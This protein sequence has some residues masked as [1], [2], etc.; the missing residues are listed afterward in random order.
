MQVSRH[1]AAFCRPDDLLAVTSSGR[2][3]SPS[4]ASHQSRHST[5][6]N[7]SLDGRG[8]DRPTS[9]PIGRRADP[10]VDIHRGCDGGKVTTRVLMALCG[11]DVFEEPP[12]VAL[13]NVLVV[14]AVPDADWDMDA[15][16]GE[17]PW[18]GKSDLVVVPA[19]ETVSERSDQ[20][21]PCSRVVPS[22]WTG[23]RSGVLR[24]GP[25]GSPCRTGF[26]QRFGCKRAPGSRGLCCYSGQS[27]T[28]DQ[29]R[30]LR[31]GLARAVPPCW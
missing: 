22:R 30:L 29:R 5:T 19:I 12:C 4:P 9:V 11:G 13:G 23:R 21:S 17:A 1:A 2:N 10:F 28:G 3:V 18:L 16:G 20:A 26:G 24:A 7:G 15:L 25:R 31:Q 27:V 8:G 6:L 14:C